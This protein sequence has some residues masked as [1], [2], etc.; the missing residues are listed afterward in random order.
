MT[1]TCHALANAIADQLNDEYQIDIDQ[2]R[3][4]N[5]L[6]NNNQHVGAVWPDEYNNYSH[7]ILAMD[8]KTKIWYSIKIKTVKRVEKFINA[9]RHVLSYYT[10]KVGNSWTDRHCVFVRQQLGDLYDCVN[11]WEDYNLCPAIP[12][13]KPGN[14][15]W[16]VQV[17]CKFAPNC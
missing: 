17:E 10:T 9:E 7:P 14:I 3:L 13:R 16:V 15:L 4:A 5:V 8:E 11:S 12:V 2:T 1:C 6:V